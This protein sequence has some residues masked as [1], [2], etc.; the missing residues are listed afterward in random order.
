MLDPRKLAAVVAG[1]NATAREQD[2]AERA[3]RR[4]LAE[5][6]VAVEG[7]VPEDI[8]AKAWPEETDA[9][10]LQDARTIVETHRDAVLALLWSEP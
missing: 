6:T 10:I 8:C 7:L 3:I 5:L 9:H 2:I 1:E 4:C